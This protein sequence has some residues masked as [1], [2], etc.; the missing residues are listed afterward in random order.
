MKR[1]VEL[2][3][4]NLAGKR[5][6]VAPGVGAG[7]G[8]AGEDV[9][10]G[11][12]VEEAAGAV[13]PSKGATAAPSTSISSSSSSSSTSA[14]LSDR[15]WLRSLAPNPATTRSL[16]EM[17]FGKLCEELHIRWSQGVHVSMSLQFEAP[18]LNS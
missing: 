13:V 2:G 6:R 5:I 7:E 12:G 8:V 15:S 11:S 9:G 16:V 10:G 3:T 1:S 18:Q 4:G 14:R 17:T